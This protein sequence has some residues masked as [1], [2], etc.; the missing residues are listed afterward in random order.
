[1][2]FRSLAIRSMALCH[3]ALSTEASGVTFPLT[4][5]NPYKAIHNNSQVKQVDIPSTTGLS[6]LCLH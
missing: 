2:A 6:I 5:S 3:R 1:M 4:F